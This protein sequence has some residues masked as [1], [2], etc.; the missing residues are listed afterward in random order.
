LLET[1]AERSLDQNASL[2]NGRWM[3]DWWMNGRWM[4]DWWMSDWWMN[5]RWIELVIQ[6]M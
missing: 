1:L 6:A 5:G 4:S 2:M 3:S